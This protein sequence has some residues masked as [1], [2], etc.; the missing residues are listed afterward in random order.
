MNGGGLSSNQSEIML[1]K[2]WINPIICDT[3]NYDS[4]ILEMVSRA[5]ECMID[6][7]FALER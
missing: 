2:L 5:Y 7:D 4:K 3:V 1:N 6:Q